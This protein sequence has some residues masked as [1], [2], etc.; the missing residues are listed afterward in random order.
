MRI[1]SFL[2]L[3]LV[4]LLLPVA[5]L[6]QQAKKDL[7]TYYIPYHVYDTQTKSWIDLETLLVALS[8]D[9]VGFLGEQHND[10][11]AHQLQL[12]IL[13]GAARR[14]PKIVLA[15]EMFERDVQPV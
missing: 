8:Q 5:S 14:R 2:A 11:C 10:Q 9:E 15:M 6:A 12:A 3:I 4:L 7:P 1:R 13:E